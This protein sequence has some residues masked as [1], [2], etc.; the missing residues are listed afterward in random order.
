MTVSVDEVRH[1]AK[2]SRL[3][4]T[5]D[6]EVAMAAQLS[7]ILGYIEQ[8]TEL[9]IEDV[10]PMSHV[11]DLVNAMRDDVV[12]HRITHEEALRSAPAADSD[13]FRVPRFLE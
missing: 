2:L 3:R 8:L 5:G 11:L 6:E 9:D 4:L 1:I 7:K 13:Y 10:E 12:E